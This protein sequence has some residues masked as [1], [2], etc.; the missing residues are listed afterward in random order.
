MFQPG[1]LAESH[2]GILYVDEIKL[3]DESIANLLLSILSDGVNVVER[4]GLSISHPC[5]PLLIA[6]FNPEEGALREVR[7]MPYG[8]L[9][10]P[11]CFVCRPAP[12][13]HVWGVEV[14]VMMSWEGAWCL[15][16]SHCLQ[17][18]LDRIAVTLSADVPTNFN[19]RVKAVTTASQFQVGRF[20]RPLHFSSHCRLLSS[21]PSERYSTQLLPQSFLSCMNR[22]L[23]QGRQH[24]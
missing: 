2:R 16:S 11:E 24:G 20:C 3:L 5:R 17:H 23:G 22:T 6:T 13:F 10:S 8:V 15:T 21:N 14:V 1:L 9:G 18:L 19:D 4:E 7:V 12:F